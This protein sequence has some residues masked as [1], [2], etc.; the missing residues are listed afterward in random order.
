MDENDSVVP[1]GCYPTMDQM[2]EMIP[3]VSI[4][5][6]QRNRGKITTFLDYWA[7]PT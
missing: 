1:P 6:T 5:N 7:I 3:F 2:A 4:Y